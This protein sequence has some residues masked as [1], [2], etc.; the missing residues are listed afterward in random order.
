MRLAPSQTD[1]S[2]K[3]TIKM[4]RTTTEARPRRAVRGISPLLSAVVDVSDELHRFSVWVVKKTASEVCQRIIAAL[5]I[6]KRLKN[7]SMS[8]QLFSQSPRNL[9][10]GGG[11]VLTMQEQQAEIHRLRGHHDA[12]LV[13]QIED[14]P[15]SS[16]HPR[17]W[18]RH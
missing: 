12:W 13:Q 1:S 9:N 8:R 14:V 2:S 11:V 4:P 16:R 10:L 17:D 7:Q 18:W 3:G 15:I 5:I 6:S